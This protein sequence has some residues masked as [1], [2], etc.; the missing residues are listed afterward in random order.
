MKRNFKWKILDWDNS[1]QASWNRKRMLSLLSKLRKKNSLQM[2]NWH[3]FEDFWSWGKHHEESVKKFHWDEKKGSFPFPFST[4]FPNISKMHRSSPLI[5]HVLCGER[6]V[7][8]RRHLK[9]KKQTVCN[10]PKYFCWNKI[11]QKK[12]KNKQTFTPNYRKK[13]HEN[14]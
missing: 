8:I 1:I 7:G 2:S 11:S 12:T 10:W 3:V 9:C 4:C 5:S 13:K 14:E 6:G